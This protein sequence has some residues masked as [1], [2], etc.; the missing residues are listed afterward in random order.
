MKKT[1]G[2][3]L[4]ELRARRGFSQKDMAAFLAKYGVEIS[5]Q[6]ISKWEKDITQ[7]SAA[8][9]LAVCSL[10]EVDD[11][12]GTFT[13]RVRKSPVSGLSE[14]G[15][16]KVEE[17][18]ADLWATG[19][20]EEADVSQT[21]ERRSLPLYRIAA[22]AGTGQF[23]D[24][25]EYDMVEAGSEVPISANF[26]VKLAGDSMEPRFSG[27]QIVWVCQQQELRDGEIGIF[28]YDGNAYCKKLSMGKDG[29]QLISLNKK[30]A[31]IPIREGAEFRVFGR[32][33]C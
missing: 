19:L 9:F 23:L 2:Q 14:A 7:P 5:N 15:R 13:G 16:R 4:A 8:Q 31:P 33:L 20:Y 18:I 1:F 12:M 28:L 6:A 3:T 22:S 21:P 32:V 29:I 10:F 27:G 24:S 26:G 25:D 17:Y 30:Y 11:V